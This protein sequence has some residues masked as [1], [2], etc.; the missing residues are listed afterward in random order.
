MDQGSLA[1]PRKSC[2]KTRDSTTFPISEVGAHGCCSCLGRQDLLLYVRIFR[3]LMFHISLT[4][5]LIRRVRGGVK[6]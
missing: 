2:S 4:F 1:K 3:I 6:R 5:Q